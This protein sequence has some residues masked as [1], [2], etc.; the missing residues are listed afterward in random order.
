MKKLAILLFFAAFALSALAQVTTGRLDGV[1]TDPQG[2][3]VPGAQVK[4]INKETGQ[5]FDTVADE[6][7]LWNIPSVAA[8]TYTVAVSHPGFKTT[9]VENVKVEINLPATV[10]TKLE[11][12]ALAETV[13]VQAGAEVLQ[14]ASATVTSTLVGRQLHEL[15]FTSRNLTELIVT[16]PGSATPGVPRSTSVYGMP[17]SALNVTKDGINIQD[18]SNKSGDGFFNAIFPR[19]DAIEEMNISAAAAGADSNA[20]GAMQVKMVTRS[21]SNSF[22]GGLFEQHRNQYFDA[23]SYFNNLNGTA[24]RDHIVFNQF[25]GFVG[26]PIKR[27]KLFFF[28]HM[29]ALQLP[30]TYTEPTDRV[31]TPD[32]LK[33]IFTYSIGGGQTRNVNLYQLAAANG[34]VS[35]PDPIIQK[36]LTQIDSLVE[37]QVGLKSRAV[38]NA[39]YNTNNLDFQS[40]GGNYRRF[41]TTRLDYNVTE[42]HHIEFVYDYQTN[43]RRPDGVNIGSASP[44]FPGTGNVLNGTEFGNQGGI[45][46]Q[47][48]AALRSTLTTHLTSEIRFGLN[49]GTV[50]FNNGI[51]PSDFAQWNGYAPSFG[52]GLTN[53]YR[54]TGQT[55]RNTPLKQ[56]NGNLTWSKGQ[57]LLNFGGSFTQVNTWTTSVNG[58]Q[59]IPGVA[60]GVATGD[61]IITGATNIFTAANFPGASATDMQTNAPALYALLTGRVSS[62]SRSVVADETSKQYGPNQPVVRNHQR[63]IGIYVQDSWRIAPRLTVNYG[64]RWDRQ[65]PPVNLN[66]VYSRPG[67]AGVWGLSGV[68]NLFMPGTLTGV[69]PTY[70]ATAP[71]EEGFATRNNQF[72]PSIGLAWQVPTDN[73]LHWLLGKNSVIRAGYAI[74]TIREDASTFAVWGTNQGRTLSLNVDP[75]NFP[76]NFGAPGSVLFRGTLPSR[77]VPSAQPVYPLALSAGNSVADFSPNL[78]TGYVQSWDIGLQRELTRDTVLEVRYVANHG[79]DLWRQVNL[80]ETNIFENG[81][82]DEFKI[83]Q[84]NLASARGCSV[85][86]AVCMSANRAKS[87]NYFGLAGQQTLPMIVTAIGSNNDATTALQIE[88]GQAGALANGIATNATRMGRLTAIGKPANLFLVNPTLGSG[89]ALLEVNGGNTNYNSLQAEVTRRFSKGLLVQFSYVWSHAITNEYSS[90]IGGSYTTLRNVGYDKSPSPYDIRQAIKANWVYELPFGSK[91]RFLSHIGNPVGRKAIEGWELASVIRLQ[92]GSPIR[93]TSGRATFNQ[94]D[95]GVILHNM[96]ASQLQDMMSIR[97]VTLAATATSGPLGAVYYLPQSLIDNTNAAFEVNGKTLKDLNPSAPYIG[98][99]DQAGQLGQ[100]VFLY[101]PGQQKW[102]FSLVKKT[103][104]TERVNLEF[105]MQALNA[106]NRTNFLLFVPGNGITTTLGVNGTG[107]GQTTGA[108][109]DL[110]NTN[111]PGGRIVEFSLRLNF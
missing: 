31:L 62:V 18:N 30:Q 28:A 65:N 63:E 26:G 105:R 77:P 74:N 89:S 42:R 87:N 38:S 19:A 45:A 35:T 75:T 107:F 84:A 36:T 76:Q 88:Q 81:F 93:L 78:R 15:P 40:K 58:T 44:V 64:V 61:P 67:Y 46:F 47:A 95:S 86:D 92:T 29:E 56:G 32:A 103:P 12:G 37:G 16:Q 83:A 52:F 22:H 73:A 80:N 23:N 91:H 48:V 94:N 55:R 20:E 34:F 3:A 98:P 4:V 39:D 11:V 111:D 9:T 49:G 13:E 57:H 106:I 1:V 17:Q 7:G 70:N 6:K 108:Y 68:G 102:D 110:S 90:G 54:T 82:S 24:P 2:A 109:K 53:P 21:G 14:T 60:F 101:G 50:V 71:G 69:T 51:N 100:R 59:I 5:A 27:N 41:P 72:S 104:I 97:K 99:A 79:T 85:G 66:N 10:N 8:A 96:T 33:G 25:G 43:I